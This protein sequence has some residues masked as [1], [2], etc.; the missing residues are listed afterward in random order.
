VSDLF[1]E[2]EE[3]EEEEEEPE[4][5][6]TLKRILAQLTQARI[7]ERI[8]TDKWQHAV[9]QTLSQYHL[10]AYAHGANIDLRQLTPEDHNLVQA[11]IDNQLKY[12]DGYATAWNQGRY[13]DRGEVALHRSEMYAAATIGTWWMGKTR[14]WPLPAWPGDGTTQC[15]TN[16]NCSWRIDVL[17]GE[18][19]ANAYWLLGGSDHCQT[20]SQRAEDWAPIQIRDGD[21]QI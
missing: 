12:L 15:K 5:P 11:V 7:D 17:E 13:N 6:T 4:A 16:C 14:G 1:E 18:G 8:S 2:P 3:E 19:N 21:L 10:A 20:C 9:G